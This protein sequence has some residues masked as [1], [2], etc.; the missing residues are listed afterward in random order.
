MLLVGYPRQL[1]EVAICKVCCR[2]LGPCW[3]TPETLKAA[4]SNGVKVKLA[5]WV[6]APALLPRGMEA[7]PLTAGMLDEIRARGIRCTPEEAKAE[8]DQA[9]ASL[10]RRVN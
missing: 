5:C 2:C 7:E 10:K 3:V 9:V 1:S 4:E 6:C 8:I